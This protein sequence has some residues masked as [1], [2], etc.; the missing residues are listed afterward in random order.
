VFMFILRDME[1]GSENFCLCSA[2]M[3]ILNKESL[4]QCTLARNV[5]LRETH[6]YSALYNQM[7]DCIFLSK[8]G[9]YT[10]VEILE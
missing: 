2:D 5:S 9:H 10:K 1:E 3:K 8:G 4:Q 6:R 7:Y